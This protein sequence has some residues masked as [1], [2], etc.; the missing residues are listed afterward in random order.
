[1]TDPNAPTE[2]PSSPLLVAV[3]WVAVGVPMLWGVWQTLRKA[4]LLFG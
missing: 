3:A 2:R 4:A 1:M